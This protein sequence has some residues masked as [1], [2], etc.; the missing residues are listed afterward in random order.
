MQWFDSDPTGSIPSSLVRWATR[1]AGLSPLPIQ[2]VGPLQKRSEDSGLFMLLGIRQ[3]ADGLPHISQEEADVLIEAFRDKLLVEIICRSLTP[4]KQDFEGI[5]AQWQAADSM[6]VDEAIRW[7]QARGD[8]SSRTD[9]ESCMSDAVSEA[10]GPI[11]GIE[12]TLSLAVTPGAI[13]AAPNVGLISSTDD[14]LQLAARSGTL[15]E[16]RSTAGRRRPLPASQQVITYQDR[17]TIVGILSQAVRAYRC[18]R[19]DQ[20]TEMAVL[21]THIVE[22]SM[23]ST[24]HRRI[25]MVLLGE[26]LIK[27]STP[28]AI[29]MEINGFA[30]QLTIRKIQRKRHECNFWVSISKLSEAWRVGKYTLLCAFPTNISNI[31]QQQERKAQII[32]QLQNGPLQRY[33][34]LAQ[35]LCQ[36]IIEHNLPQERLII[37]FYRYKEHEPL[38]EQTFKAF[39]NLDICPRLLIPRIRSV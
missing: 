10:S 18:T 21:W 2:K 26:R 29:S 30:D 38:T 12:D 32:S 39:I 9:G 5:V 28:E 16:L 11:I 19:M 37:D 25:A 4:S 14:T 3:I 17:K 22:E 36:A 20:H 8:P 1:H 7:A 33:L 31:R 13:H 35:K 6:F 23:S 15:E 27:P 24:F 34:E